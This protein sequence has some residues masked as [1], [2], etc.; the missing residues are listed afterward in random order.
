MKI[1]QYIPSESVK[2]GNSNGT[3]LLVVP[4]LPV[5]KCL[6]SYHRSAVL[7]VSIQKEAWKLQSKA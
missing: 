1:F 3:K 5:M 6:N 7:I 2:Q 4:H